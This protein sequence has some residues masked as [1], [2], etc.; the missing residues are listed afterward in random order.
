VKLDRFQEGSICHLVFKAQ[1]FAPAPNVQT[2]SMDM[3][4][5]IFSGTF[6]GEAD[7]EGKSFLFETEASHGAIMW[8]VDVDS[9][10]M[11]GRMMNSSDI[12]KV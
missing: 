11:M 6:H 4:L 10:L 12:A 7:D 9:V 3:L 2:Q 1:P 5:N 8:E